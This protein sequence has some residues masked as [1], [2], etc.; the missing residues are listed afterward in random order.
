MKKKDPISLQTLHSDLSDYMSLNRFSEAKVL[1]D[2]NHDS[3]DVMYGDGRYFLFSVRYKNLEMLEA[4]LD[5]FK[6]TKIEKDDL[7][8]K[9]RGARHELRE[10][11]QDAKDQFG[12][13]KQIDKLTSEYSSSSEEDDDNEQ[14]LTGFEEELA[15]L[16]KHDTEHYESY[17]ESYHSKPIIGQ[18]IPHE[19]F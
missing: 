1:L 8:L 9:S 18:D 12:S 2:R 16:G 3:V 7:S 10:I 15:E 11:L 14:D 19:V 13:T 4:L 5:L 17:D 6:E